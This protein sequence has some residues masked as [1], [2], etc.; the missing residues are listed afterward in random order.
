MK[1]ESAGPEESGVGLGLQIVPTMSAADVIGIVTAAEDLGYD[2][3]MI[4]DEGLMHD[5]YALLATAAQATSSIRL[6]AVT[7]PYTRHPAVTAAAVA[8]VDELSGGRAFLTLVAGGSMVLSPLGITRDHPVDRLDEA[9]SILSGLWSGETIDF[10]GNHFRMS[11]ARLST[12]PRDIPLW[13]AARG[14][15]MLRLAG[16]RADAVVLM[17]RS[18]LG[19]ALAIVNT[20]GSPARVYLDR[21]AY[22]A[23]MIEESRELYAWA[24]VDTPART[25]ANLGADVALVNEARDALAAGRPEAIAELIDDE[26]IAAY[27]IAGTPH[28][29]ATQLRAVVA[30]HSLDAFF[31]N[32][33]GGDREGNTRILSDV[34]EMVRDR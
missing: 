31:V 13:V 5:V 24:L 1:P 28:Q 18:D 4:A 25:L 34:Y 21:L 27:Q 14:P 11:G 20:A 33:T 26:M 23:R 17:A 10:Q 19:D 2:Y 22:T 9:I 29:C 6:G 15:R 8:S 16:R 32:I 7:N 12:A 30:E 3:C